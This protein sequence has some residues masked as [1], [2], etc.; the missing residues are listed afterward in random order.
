QHEGPVAAIAHA[1]GKRE[2]DADR[3]SMPER[4]GRC[5]DTRHHPVFG[6]P[7]E[8]AVG[9]AKTFEFGKGKEA[10][11]GEQ[12]VE[13]EAAVPLAQDRAVAAGVARVL[14]IDAKYV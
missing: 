12:R 10:A 9:S 7:P 8:D 4:A 14:R 11:I 1:G 6:V 13:R 5:F 3:Q 2:T